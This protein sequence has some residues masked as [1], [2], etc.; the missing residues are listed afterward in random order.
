MEIHGSSLNFSALRT[1]PQ[2][3]GK[4]VAVSKPSQDGNQDARQQQSFA[5]SGQ[6][7]DEVEKILAD[8]GLPRFLTAPETI[9]PPVDIRRLNAINAYANQSRQPLLEQ[10]GRLV[11]GIDL[12]V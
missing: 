9:N 5:P 7:P 2:I 1:S 12:F 6:A 3:A 8:A 10:R 4:P 11:S